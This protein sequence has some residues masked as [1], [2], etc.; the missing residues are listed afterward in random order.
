MSNF[1]EFKKAA[2]DTFGTIAEFSSEAYRIAEDKA[3]TLAR[4]AKLTAS[5]TKQRTII[6]R[7]HI[8]IGMTYYRL[9]KDSPDAALKDSCDTITASLNRIASMEKELEE[10]RKRV[11]YGDKNSCCGENAESP[12]DCCAGEENTDACCETE[13]SEIQCGDAETGEDAGDEAP[14][15]EV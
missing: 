8:E 15:N 3:K 12:D 9:F 2:K 1:D 5:I 11:Y 7:K 6:R 13:P 10:L 4:R 14:D